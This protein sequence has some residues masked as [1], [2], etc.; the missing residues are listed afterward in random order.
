MSTQESNL[1]E[2]NNMLNQDHWKTGKLKEMG[3]C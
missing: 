3:N 2:R 1:E